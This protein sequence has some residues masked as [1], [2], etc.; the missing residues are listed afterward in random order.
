[1]VGICV[2][3]SRYIHFPICKGRGGGGIMKLQVKPVKREGEK[4][5]AEFCG[6]DR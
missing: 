1:M 5:F 3:V 2:C 4:R 6:G